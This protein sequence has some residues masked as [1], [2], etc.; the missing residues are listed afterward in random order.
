[1]SE[2]QA[3]P[4]EITQMHR[5][6]AKAAFATIFFGLLLT[7]VGESLAADQSGPQHSKSI[8]VREMIAAL[9]GPQKAIP[10]LSGLETFVELYLRPLRQT[11]TAQG[12]DEQVLLAAMEDKGRTL[13]R[14]LC[15]ASFLL[16]L[17]N[18]Q[19][20]AFVVKCLDGEHGAVGKKNAPFVL[21]CE[22]N[23]QD[24]TWR[25]QQILRL[26]KLDDRGASYDAAWDA[27]CQRAGE[28]KLVQAVEPLIDILRH[29]PDDREAALALGRIGDRRATPRLLETVE[30]KGHIQEGQ[31]YALQMLGAPELP[32]ILLRHLDHYPCI[33][34][35]GDLG[36]KESIEPLKKIVA[37]SNDAYL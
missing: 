29:R 30:H 17:D 19:A 32:T 7:T 2:A 3:I 14:R 23:D 16:D 8:P 27:I 15:I 11:Y 25:K 13:E 21:A 26:I 10:G 5:H 33:D 9:D 18:Q 20:R 22:D 36:A 1:L 34:L 12:K 24:L 6:F 37:Q 35:L 4:P 28:L 31:M